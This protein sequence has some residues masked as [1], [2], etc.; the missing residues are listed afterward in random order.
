MDK[1]K[2]LISGHIVDSEF[3]HIKVSYLKKDTLEN[4]EQNFN[5][6]EEFTE[7]YKKQDFNCYPTISSSSQYQYKIEIFCSY[8]TK[9]YLEN[10]FEFSNNLF[11]FWTYDYFIKAPSIPNFNLIEEVNG[12]IKN[13]VN[14]IKNITFS[15]LL[16]KDIKNFYTNK[17]LNGILDFVLNM[18]KIEKQIKNNKDNKNLI[19]ILLDSWV[20][21]FYEICHKPPNSDHIFFSKCNKFYRKY[22][23]ELSELEK[24]LEN[25]SDYVFYKN[26]KKPDDEQ[27][28]KADRRKSWVYLARNESGTVHLINFSNKNINSMFEN[29]LLCWIYKNFKQQGLEIVLSFIKQ[30]N[31]ICVNLCSLYFFIKS[32][33]MH[34]KHSKHSSFDFEGAKAFLFHSSFF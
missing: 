14:N 31:E 18:N 34:T 21:K 6:L 10:N 1:N 20:V 19:L 17:Y 9:E 13:K 11:D 33:L 12:K 24:D 23:P 16:K 30:V 3:E 26:N 29:N 2:E 5:N 15:P 28:E 8:E 25:I 32:N 22:V 27:K 4:R 7:W